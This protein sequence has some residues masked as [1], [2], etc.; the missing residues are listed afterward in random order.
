[1]LIVRK[2]SNRALVYSGKGMRL[3][4]IITLS[5]T[6]KRSMYV[7]Q[8]KVYIWWCDHGRSVFF[9]V[10]KAG[11]IKQGAEKKD[12]FATK[13]SIVRTMIS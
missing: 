9:D 1:M 11:H 5:L 10:K 6:K 3:K 8:K 12:H 4:L 2:I 7:Y 13:I